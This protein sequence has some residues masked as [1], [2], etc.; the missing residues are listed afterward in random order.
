MRKKPYVEGRRF[1]LGGRRRQK[2]GFLLGPGLGLGFK[3]VKKLFG[4]RRRRRR[5]RRRW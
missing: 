5:R 3:L 2:G 4:G 1:Y